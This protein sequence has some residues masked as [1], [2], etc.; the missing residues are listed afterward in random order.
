MNYSS[1]QQG[2]RQRRGEAG[3]IE[4]GGPKQ[5]HHVGDRYRRFEFPWADGR[6]AGG[7]SAGQD[8]EAWTELED[9]Q[10]CLKGHVMEA[11]GSGLR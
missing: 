4:P 8:Q 9:R 5:A 1:P 7:A 2:K 10:A 3:G 6:A 11:R